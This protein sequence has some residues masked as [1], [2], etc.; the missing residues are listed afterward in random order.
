VN[1]EKF[2]ASEA[3]RIME[4]IIGG[5]KVSAILV[6]ESFSHREEMYLSVTLDR[7]ER[8]YVSIASKTGG[9]DVESLSGKRVEKVSLTGLTEGLAK[10]ITSDLGLS[11]HVAEEFSDILLNLERLSR[12]EECELAEINPLAL[13]Y[14]GKLLS[15]DAKVIIDDN[16]LFRHPEFSRLHPEDEF[17]GRGRTCHRSGDYWPLRQFAYQA[18]AQ[19]WNKNRSVGL[20]K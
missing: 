10:R 8:S 18:D 12:E 2:A 19:I 3:K 7:G 16:A 5:E 20:K 17:D 9:V 11:G 13:G 6:E 1:D 15:L 4:M 14:D